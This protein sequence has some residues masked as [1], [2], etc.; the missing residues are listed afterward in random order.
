MRA[1]TRR[2]PS[3]QYQ[4]LALRIAYDDF[5]ICHFEESR[6]GIAKLPIGEE[7]FNVGGSLHDE[8]TLNRG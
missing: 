7:G 2:L 5:H 4:L 8:G 3:S 1:S 6:E